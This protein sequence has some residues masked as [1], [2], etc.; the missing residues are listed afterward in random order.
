MYYPLKYLKASSASVIV[1]FFNFNVYE[2]L[3][4]FSWLHLQVFL[5]YYFQIIHFYFYE[6]RLWEFVFNKLVG[7]GEFLL[8]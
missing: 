5:F 8:E 6:C 7:G 4:Y 1:S 2:Y 3:T